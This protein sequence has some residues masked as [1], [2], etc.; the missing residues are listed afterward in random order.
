[1]LRLILKLISMDCTT[2]SSGR[3]IPISTA[4]DKEWKAYAIQQCSAL[5]PHLQAF[6]LERFGYKPSYIKTR[7]HSLFGTVTA[8]TK[9]YDLYIRLFGGPD[10]FWPRERL[11]LAR[12]IFLEERAGHGRALMSLLIE[13]A[14]LL[15]YRYI[16]IESTNPNSS[17]F[18]LRL[19]FT[20]DEHGHNWIADI[21]TLKT[22]LGLDS[23]AV[24]Q[25]RL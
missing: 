6:I 11:V 4:T 14:P 3:P 16:G 25:G 22:G 20:P 21:E 5:L 7:L 19:G 17:A 15:G 10:D 9:Q 2:P 13:L 8:L 24:G 18:A 12:I 1:M 23:T